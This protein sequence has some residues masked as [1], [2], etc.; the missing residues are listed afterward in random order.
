MSSLPV[1]LRLTLAFTAVMAAVLA[2]TG[3]F[4]YLRL[5][6]ELD[7]SLE[8]SL[9][10]RADEVS[11]LAGTAGSPLNSAA[12]DPL[13]PERES[14]SQVIGAG[15]EVIDGTTNRRA[16]SQDQ[17]T[18]ARRG[19]LFAD[20]GP[21]P[22]VDDPVRMLAKP[23]ERGG[24]DLVVV[25]G[26]SRD[27][28]DEALSS[29]L[30]LLLTGGPVTLLLTAL[31]GYGLTSVAMRPIDE[32]VDRLERS[33]ERERGFV[34]SASHE[35]RTPLALLKGELELALRAGRSPE[36]L[37]AAI[38]SA[39]EESDRLIQLAEDLLVLAR[40]DEGKLPVRPEP[41]Q[42][43]ELLEAVARRFENR[44]DGRLRIEADPGLVV[45]ADRMR[46]EQALSNLVDNA[47]R[48]AEGPVT[49]AASSS[50]GSV[51]LR[52]RDEGPGFPEEL[53]DTAFE[54]FTRGDRAR[55]RGGT[56]L[57]LVTADEAGSARTGYRLG[58]QPPEGGAEVGIELPA[59]AHSLGGQGPLAVS[60]IP[61]RWRPAASPKLPSC[62]TCPRPQSEVSSRRARWRPGRSTG[63][64]ESR[65]T[66][67]SVRG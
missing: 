30:W 66:P 27:D 67:S 43:D 46:V 44:S 47:L 26:A 39:A 50:A 65:G 5:E 58:R 54:R 49:L 38:G 33:V 17:L 34:A 31:A 2:A 61:L 28:R 16:L 3:A 37:R 56:G 48:Y 53:I 55:A 19:P 36:E 64:G 9:R 29:L 7:A 23:V 45:E 63:A 10:S 1:R 24:R 12:E 4:L 22:G 20:R 15:G 60:E 41:L 6:N 13:A 40:F 21:F 14:F 42:L 11:A 25:V 32:L 57:G 18:R 51:E 35:L 59:R 8:R 52:V 62:W